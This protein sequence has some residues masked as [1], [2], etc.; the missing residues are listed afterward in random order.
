MKATKLPKNFIA[1][2]ISRK[3][4]EIM[5]NPLCV[6]H[7]KEIVKYFCNTCEKLICPECILDH[8]GHEFVRREESCFV[9][10]ENAVGIKQ[11]IEESCESANGLIMK[12][13][14]ALQFLD[15]KQEYDL[16]KLDK[17]Y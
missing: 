12:G 11:M 10:K 17:E 6:V 7:T 9:I 3:H 16:K 15:K 13:E 1:L 5:K 4:S 8:S 14:N 2:E